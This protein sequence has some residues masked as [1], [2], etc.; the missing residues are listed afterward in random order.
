MICNVIEREL[1]YAELADPCMKDQAALPVR[2][3]GIMRDLDVCLMTASKPLRNHE[4]VA[5]EA[6]RRLWKP[7]G[8]RRTDYRAMQDIHRSSIAKGD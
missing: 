7:A 4:D 3:K 6:P 8:E 2:M 5:E 1:G